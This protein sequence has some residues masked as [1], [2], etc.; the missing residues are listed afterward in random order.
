MKTILLLILPA[1]VLTAALPAQNESAPRFAPHEI[2][3]AASGSYANPYVEVSAVATL[4]EPDGRT[5]RTL[6]LFWDGGE[7]W[8][9]RFAPDTIG[10]WQWAV[11]SSDRGLDG[12]QGTFRCVASNRRGSI[13]PRS[14]A[15]RHFQYQNG[16]HMW[17]LGDTAWGFVTDHAQE[18]HDRAAV[19]RYLSNR[20]AQGFNA[21]HFMLLSEVGWPNRGGPPWTDLGSERI[22]P[23]YF[24]E[25]DAR[26][27]LANAH[28]MVAG[29]V[30]G[31]GHKG[32]NES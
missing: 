17:F 31:W 14:D 8:K 26:I 29:V 32:R 13:Q 19:Q 5:T 11:K 3:F 2:T 4:T 22:N 12:R 30:V 27:A 25:A 21:L 1:L 10:T 16:E 18:K 20:S 23:D 6:P 28:G 7:T 9:L 24:R 15:P